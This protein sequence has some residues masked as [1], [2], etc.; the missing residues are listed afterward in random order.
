M[1]SHGY[2]QNA[3]AFFFRQRFFALRLALVVAGIYLVQLGFKKPLLYVPVMGDA[4]FHEDAN[5]GAEKAR[6]IFG[7]MAAA[8]V[9][10]LFRARYLAGLLGGAGTAV[11]LASITAIR[12]VGLERIETMRQN[13]YMQN[14]A[15]ELA[16]GIKT[17]D[18][19]WIITAGC[20]LV[21]LAG[22]FP[23]SKAPPPPP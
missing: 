14:M 22:F 7:L 21:L 6:L 15:E 4:F 20:A 2:L 18:G 9:A 19:L 13:R 10:G 3:A 23:C 5:G 1:K 16:K 11:F 17:G 12:R 8:G